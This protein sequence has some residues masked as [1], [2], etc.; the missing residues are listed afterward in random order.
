MGHAP[1]LDEEGGVRE[2]FIEEVMN[3]VCALKGIEWCW[4][5]KRGLD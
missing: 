1:N 4:G 3:D 5:H 2:G